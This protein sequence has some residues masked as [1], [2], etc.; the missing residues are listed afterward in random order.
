MIHIKL[1]INE[2]LQVNFTGIVEWSNGAKVWY[3]E[4]KKHREDGPA[5]EWDNGFKYWYKNGLQHR[6][7]G[8]AIEYYPEY[9]HE[10]LEDYRE[11][12]LEGK[13]YSSSWLTG[14]K[15]IL[16]EEPYPKYPKILIYKILEKN[17][18]EEYLLIPGMKE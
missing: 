4:G 18:I 16:S 17:K 9:E 12:Y 5:I 7:D 11:W 10:D 14:D 13:K 6:E 1:N 2:S 8:P 15:L 3:K